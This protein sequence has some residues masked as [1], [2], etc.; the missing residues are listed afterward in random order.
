MP[1]P[2]PPGYSEQE[3]Q[4]LNPAYPLS[5][6]RMKHIEAGVAAD[7]AFTKAVE[8]YIKS[9]EG[10]PASVATSSGTD[11]LG[12]THIL[13]TSSIQAPSLRQFVCVTDAPWSAPCNAK[14]VTDGSIEAGSTELHASE[15]A[16]TT[17]DV[18]KRVEV[19]E[20]SGPGTPLATTISSVAAGVATL[21]APATVA[22]TG[23]T[24]TWGN[25]DTTAFQEAHNALSQHGGGTL[26]VPPGGEATGYYIAGVHPQ[27]NVTIIAYGATIYLTHAETNCGFQ[28]TSTTNS[29]PLTNWSLYGASMPGDALTYGS[30]TRAPVFISYIGSNNIRVKDCDFSANLDCGVFVQDC[31]DVW[32]KDNLVANCCRHTGRN[33]INVGFTGTGAGAGGVVNVSGNTLRATNAPQ[34]QGITL[35]SVGAPLAASY[36][37]NVV[38]ANNI[39]TGELPAAITFEVGW[40]G[41]GE[42]GGNIVISGNIIGVTGP[43]SS[44]ISTGGK[45]GAS[46]AEK[47][48]ITGNVITGT[49]GISVDGQYVTVT[50]NVVN[51]TALTGGAISTTAPHY[52]PTVTLAEGSAEATAVTFP[53]AEEA[54]FVVNGDVVTSSH[55]PKGTYIVSGAG[56]ATWVLSQKAEAGAGTATVTVAATTKYVVIT[57][58]TIGMPLNGATAMSI[59]HASYTLVAANTISWPTGSTT[60]NSGA[61]TVEA[62]HRT[63]VLHNTIDYAP[64][65][66]LKL[67]ESHN[68]EVTGNRVHN[69]NQVTA[70]ICVELRYC[71][72][73]EVD[74]NKFLDDEAVS[75]M[76][77]AIEAPTGEPSSDIKFRRN[78]IIGATSNHPIQALTY[79]TDVA[80]NYME[81]GK[82]NPAEPA[83]P[84]VPES[85]KAYINENPYPEYLIISG[86]TVTKIEISRNEGTTY[87]LTG[88]TAG[89]LYLRPGDRLKLTWSGEPT[90][91]ETMPA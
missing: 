77:F 55:L 37:L 39:V 11:A 76:T 10:L 8:E 80:G 48:S 17:A 33:Y 88:V 4:D 29:A 34:V 5:A 46:P 53:N 69:V 25:T 32:I 26:V 28:A 3:W 75:H 41:A 72:H 58:N 30:G 12:R 47:V 24:V 36:P 74:D 89:Q 20:A 21:A 31:Y 44:A 90:V 1:E 79:F 70:G 38:V 66:G 14:R 63:R 22:V 59:H 16:F 56:T 57:G 67:E 6:L 35:G 91:F 45:V 86:G 73:I 65:Y 43:L 50:G 68:V 42:G 83:K 7:E 62:C 51:I 15:A 54:Q 19:T 52:E 85:G 87:Y 27:S 61:I 40:D 9:G 49:G 78:T 2:T 71:A 13:R 84:A 82:Y 64:S 81:P 18:G 60:A 23:A